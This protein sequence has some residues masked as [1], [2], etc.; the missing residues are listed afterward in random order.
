MQL[1]ISWITS[2]DIRIFFSEPELVTPATPAPTPAPEPYVSTR[3]NRINI[4]QRRKRITYS[5]TS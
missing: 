5:I 3:E 1:Q 4:L 2:N